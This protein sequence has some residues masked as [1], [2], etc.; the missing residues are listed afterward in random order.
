ME[1][2]IRIHKLGLEVDPLSIEMIFF[3]GIAY[4]WIEQF[5]EA[6]PYL[7]KV[8]EMVPNHRTAWEF[9]LRN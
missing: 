7:N 2:A 1:G 9:D 3:M 6:L 8:V 5:D 4:L